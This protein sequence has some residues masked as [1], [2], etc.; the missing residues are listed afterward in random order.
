MTEFSPD[1]FAVGWIAAWNAHDIE[2]IL[3]HYAEDI[4]FTSPVAQAFIGEGRVRGLVDLRA[5]WARGLSV[6]RALHFD[7]LHILHGDGFLTLL[8]T[9]ERNQMV[10]ET[11]EF[12]GRGRVIR[13][14]ACYGEAAG[15][16]TDVGPHSQVKR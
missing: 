2:A 7:L 6:N 12:D 5:Y 3:S 10:A 13:A 11:F 15:P 16:S 4:E 8:Y 1:A 9:N 14:C